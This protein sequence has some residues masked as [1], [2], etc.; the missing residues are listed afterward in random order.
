M[1]SATSNDLKL[2]YRAPVQRFVRPRV[3]T[4]ISSGPSIPLAF[5]S[6]SLPLLP[7]SDTTADLLL[8]PPVRLCSHSTLPNAL[9]PSLPLLQAP[10]SILLPHGQQLPV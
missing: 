2:A 9:L 8:L 10:R 5:P 4:T 6:L 7:V 1:H 3:S